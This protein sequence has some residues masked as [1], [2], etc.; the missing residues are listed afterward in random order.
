MKRVEVMSFI[1][2]ADSTTGGSS[3]TEYYAVLEDAK[4]QADYLHNHP[5]FMNATLTGPAYAGPKDRMTHHD[6]LVG[7]WM[8]AALDDRKVCPSMKFDLNLWMDS[9]EWV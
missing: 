4:K 1:V 9:K 3:I 7:A 6:Q 5:G 8:A 2:T